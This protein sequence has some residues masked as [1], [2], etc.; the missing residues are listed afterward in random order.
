MTEEERYYASYWFEEGDSTW[1]ECCDE[2]T[3]VI[4]VKSAK[5]DGTIDE[6][7]IGPPTS[8]FFGKYI[9][10]NITE[11]W[12]LIELTKSPLFNHILYSDVEYWKRLLECIQINFP[13]E[14]AEIVAEIKEVIYNDDSEND[15]YMV[16]LKQLQQNTST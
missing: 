14:I 11:S 10:E 2:Y 12:E 4:K 1:C 13:D 7:E 5:E 16:L 8:D 15:K 9:I 3:K 6:Q